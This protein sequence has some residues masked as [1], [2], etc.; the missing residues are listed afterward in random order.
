MNTNIT[1]K[2]DIKDF[3]EIRRENG[4]FLLKRFKFLKKDRR[5]EILFCENVEKRW[6]G[7]NTRKF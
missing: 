7:E 4:I 3:N 2:R 5:K 1:V 6:A